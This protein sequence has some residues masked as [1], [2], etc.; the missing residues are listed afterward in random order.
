MDI[1]IDGFDL[2]NALDTRFSWK[3]QGPIRNVSEM[4]RTL[5]WNKSAIDE[6]WLD[7]LKSRWWASNFDKIEELTPDQIKMRSFG[8]RLVKFGGS[9]LSV[10]TVDEDLIKLETRGQLWYPDGTL[11]MRGEPSQ[12]HSNSALLWDANR[13]KNNLSIATGY[14]LSD[15]GIWRQHSWCVLEKARSVKIVETTV[16]RTAYFGFVLTED[17]SDE[18]YSNNAY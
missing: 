5:T 4:P 2:Y 12:C 7:R 10:Q 14:A 6:S 17:E 8:E 18:F 11:M 13:D 16:K 3:K 15:D 1:P 9:Q